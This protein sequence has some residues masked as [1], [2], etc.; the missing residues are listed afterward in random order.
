M[1]GTRRVADEIGDL[2]EQRE[3]GCHYQRGERRERAEIDKRGGTACEK[4]RK[5][6]SERETCKYSESR[7]RETEQDTRPTRK[8][9]GAQ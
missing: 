4:K 9:R 2:R 1:I 6:D 7:D 3:A 8:Q 5:I